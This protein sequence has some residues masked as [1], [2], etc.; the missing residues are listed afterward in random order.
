MIL[1]L[2]YVFLLFAILF[3]SNMHA[4][5]KYKVMYLDKIV[6][7]RRVCKIVLLVSYLFCLFAQIKY[8]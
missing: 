1:Y 5:I 2:F 8:V 7:R 6:N 4:V 3:L